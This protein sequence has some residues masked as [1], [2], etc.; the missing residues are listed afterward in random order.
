MRICSL[1]SE[2]RTIF[3]PKICDFPY[4][5]SNLTKNLIPYFSVTGAS[6]GLLHSSCNSLRRAFVDGLIAKCCRCNVPP[7]P[8]KMPS[9]RHTNHTLFQ[10]KMIKSIPYFRP[11]R[12]KN[13]TLRR[14]TYQYIPYT[15]VP[16]GPL[17]H[18]S[19]H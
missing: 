7:P 6:D 16:P 18:P 5:I 19:N 17:I 1:L 8:K 2:T 14:R 9:S 12:P 11:K 3:Q 13:H 15:V 4:P 10:T